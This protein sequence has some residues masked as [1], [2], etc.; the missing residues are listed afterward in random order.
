MTKWMLRTFY[1]RNNIIWKK[2]SY[3]YRGEVNAGP[4]LDRMRNV[5]A[6]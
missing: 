1:L 6:A 5:F 2:A 3:A 4:R